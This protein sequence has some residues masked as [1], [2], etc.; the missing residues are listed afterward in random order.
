MLQYFY[1]HLVRHVYFFSQYNKLV[2]IL[3]EKRT[4]DVAKVLL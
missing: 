3:F 1:L 4:R 2:L